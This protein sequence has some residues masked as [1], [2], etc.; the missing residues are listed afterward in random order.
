MT[1]FSLE[2]KLHDKARGINVSI[3]RSIVEQNRP[4][5]TYYLDLSS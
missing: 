3:N 2:T 1:L 4:L 5:F